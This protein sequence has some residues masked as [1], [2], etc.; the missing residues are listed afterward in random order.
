[1]QADYKVLCREH[2]SAADHRGIESPEYSGRCKRE[3][4]QL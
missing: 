4:A 2:S 3:T 1:M